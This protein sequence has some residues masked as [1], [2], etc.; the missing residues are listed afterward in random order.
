MQTAVLQIEVSSAFTLR[1]AGFGV[2]PKLLDAIFEMV[3]HRKSCQFS[4]G[5]F[6]LSSHPIGDFFGIKV[7]HPPVG[8]CDL[9]PVVVLD[10]IHRLRC[11]VGDWTLR[12]L[13]IAPTH[14]NNRQNG[15]KTWLSSK[16]TAPCMK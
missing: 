11:G 5:H 13:L 7:L 12:F 3:A 10:D 16:H 15:G 9:R 4:G 8:I 14:Q 2:I 6:V 1:N